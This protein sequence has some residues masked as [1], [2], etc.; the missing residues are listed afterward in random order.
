[1]TASSLRSLR[2]PNFRLYLT[3]QGLSQIGTWFQL[4][5]E[6]WVI[7]ELTG[8]GKALGVHSI[9]RFGPLM[10]VGIPGTLFSGRF[11]RRKFLIATSSFYGLVTLT[12]AIVGWTWSVS[13]PLIYI[14]VFIQGVLFSL[15]NPV[16][17]AFIRDLTNDANMSNSMSLNSS[18]EVLTRTIGPALAGIMIVTIGAPWCF[19]L[20]ALSF[21]A[22]VTALVLMD[23]T[24][25]RPAQRMNRESGQIRA[26]FRYAWSNRRI[27]RT[28]A[29][30]TVVFV[31]IWNW[32]VILPVYASEELGGDASLYGLLVALLG[33]GAFI[34]T[35]VVA[36]LTT[37]TGRYFRIVSAFLAVALLITATAPSLAFAVLGLALIGAAGTAFQIGAIT[38]L[39]LEC[40]DLMSTRVLALSS[41]TSTG[42]K[43][44]MGILAGSIMD[45][46]DSRVAFG[47]GAAAAA[48]LLLFLTLSRLPPAVAAPTESPGPAPSSAASDTGSSDERL[49]ND[50][51]VA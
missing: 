35:L 11:D 29:M 9:L 49:P 39:Q 34:G 6:M 23:T 8:S 30:T 7:F 50:E 12:M 47:V 26:G 10:L 42:A 33:L 14:G 51:S 15:Y 1:M 40:D 37:I 22:F 41:V 21:S 19:A 20:N 18:M 46:A 32:Q 45:S 36:R 43:P 13:L 38:R 25:L 28:L 31:F 24:K 16:R 17:R 44:V 3:G 2:N 5:T 4:T 48:C 27:R